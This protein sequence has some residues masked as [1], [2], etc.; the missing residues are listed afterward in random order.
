[1]CGRYR[2][3]R[4]DKLAGRFA[5]ETDDDWAPRFNIAPAQNIPVILQ[6][7]EEPKRFGSKMRWGFPSWAKDACC[8][9]TRKQHPTREANLTAYPA[10]A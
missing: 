3:T 7:P 5:V 10:L 2:L 6:H 4:P 1:M 8:P 9:P